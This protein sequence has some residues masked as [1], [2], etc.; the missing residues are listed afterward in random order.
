MTVLFNA[1]HD[2]HKIGLTIP[3]LN[4]MKSICIGNAMW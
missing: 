1:G 3:S 2:N 4:L